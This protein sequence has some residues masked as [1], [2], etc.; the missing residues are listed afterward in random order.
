MIE[1]TKILC[2]GKATLSDIP[3][4]EINITTKDEDSEV[5]FGQKSED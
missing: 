1:K 5:S 2:A 3:T 4:V